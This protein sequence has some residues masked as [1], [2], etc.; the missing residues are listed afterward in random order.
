MIE[1]VFSCWGQLSFKVFKS[2]SPQTCPI[3]ISFDDLLKAVM[4]IHAMAYMSRMIKHGNKYS[5]FALITKNDSF[6]QRAVF[7]RLVIL[8]L[9]R[10]DYFDV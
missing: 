10:E 9:Y 4:Y 8:A 7:D 3:D 5:H 2:D 1:H 6:R